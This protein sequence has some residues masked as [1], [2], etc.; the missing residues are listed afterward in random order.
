MMDALAFIIGFLLGI[1]TGLLPGIH[2][3]LLA[4]ILSTASLPPD[5][6]AI[7]LIAMVPANII[8][9]FIITVF[10]GIP[11]GST[12]II[13]LP[14]QRMTIQGRGLTALKVVLLSTLLATL[15]SGLFIYPSLFLFPFVYSIL[16]PFMKYIVLTFSVIFILKSKKPFLAFLVFL[17]SGLLGCFSLKSGIYDPFLPLF[18][19]MFAISALLNIGENTLPE[20]KTEEPFRLILIPYIMLGV[21]L[22]MFADLLP[23]VS[24]PAQVATLM[25]LIIPTDSLMYISSVSSIAVSESVFSLSTEA[26]LNK[27]RIGT[28]AWLAQFIDIGNNLPLLLAAFLFSAALTTIL[29]Y[30]AR[31]RISK[32]A[33]LNS[34]PLAI[35]LIFYLFAVVAILDG[36]AGI[37]ILLVGTALGWFTVRLGIER[38][39]MMGAV[40]LPTLLLLFRIFI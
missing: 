5:F 25:S 37:I 3:N 10:F 32:I 12:F 7:L 14:A 20:Q 21:A 27:S 9:S 35:I 38:T 1:F 4:S 33:V 19:G 31:K 2:P 11:E 23:G 15:F 30:K 13:T 17:S 26:S 36:F 8:T 34:R 16:S 40:I 28:T 6:M 24:S 18:S 22:G 39:Q 29:L